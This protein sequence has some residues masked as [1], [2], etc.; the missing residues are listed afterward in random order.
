MLLMNMS[1]QIVT[2]T[3]EQKKLF[4]LSIPVYIETLTTIAGWD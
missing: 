3:S 4:N 2:N 1:G